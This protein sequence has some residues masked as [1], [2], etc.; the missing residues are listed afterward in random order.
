MGICGSNIGDIGLSHIISTDIK[1]RIINW[2][3]PNS[4][5]PE[6]Q[7]VQKIESDH[8]LITNGI[9]YVSFSAPRNIITKD[10][11]GNRIVW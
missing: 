10:D 3:M 5:N 2:Q 7:F 11:D 4:S 9:S 8:S 6:L 1:G